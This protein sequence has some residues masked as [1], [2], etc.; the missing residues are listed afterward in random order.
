MTEID[1]IK[2]SLYHIQTIYPLRYRCRFPHISQWL[3]LAFYFF[4]FHTKFEALPGSSSLHRSP[5]I[6]PMDRDTLGSSGNM[7]RD[8]WGRCSVFSGSW[9]ET[10]VAILAPWTETQMNVSALG[11]RQ[12]LPLSST[13]VPW[14]EIQFTCL[15]SQ[16]KHW[17]I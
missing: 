14:T 7:D 13:S 6:Q 1:V 12:S 3:W 16:E 9:T 2:K 10:H 8:S 17:N 4:F 5:W 15:F 11:Q